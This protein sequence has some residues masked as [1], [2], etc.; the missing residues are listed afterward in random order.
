MESSI[1][2]EQF[3]RKYNSSNPFEIV[4]K[5]KKECRDVNGEF[6]FLWHNCQ[7]DTDVKKDLYKLLVN[8]YD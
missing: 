2:S 3:F 8:P 1:F 4:L 7:L 5:L 6:L